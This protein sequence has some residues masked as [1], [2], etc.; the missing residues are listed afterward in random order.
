MQV[1]FNLE[2]SV[3]IHEK[4]EVAY[5]TMRSLFKTEIELLYSQ[6]SLISKRGVEVTSYM[7]DDEHGEL[8]IAVFD[9]TDNID[10]K[11]IEDHDE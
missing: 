7:T 6:L 5:N 2:I 10:A 1:R 11:D 8:T 4:N 3:D 9:N